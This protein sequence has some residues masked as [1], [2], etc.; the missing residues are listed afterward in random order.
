[1]YSYNKFSKKNITYLFRWYFFINNL[2]LISKK[3][4]LNLILSS[5]AYNY[6]K[7]ILSLKNHS[8]FFDY[9]NFI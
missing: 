9:V 5:K 2:S 3:I 4:A 7:N 1:M 6:T 8:K